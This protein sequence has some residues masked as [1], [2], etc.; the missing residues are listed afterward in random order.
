MKTK[1]KPK[2]LLNR[3]LN[4]SVGDFATIYDDKD[5]VEVYIVKDIIDNTAILYKLSLTYEKDDIYMDEI[6]IDL[7]NVIYIDESFVS[8]N[9]YLWTFREKF[10]LDI[11]K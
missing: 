10:L 1:L 2:D 11:K 7:D 6:E 5:Y 9:G 4:V 3:N 8:V